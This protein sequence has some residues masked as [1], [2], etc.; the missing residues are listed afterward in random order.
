MPKVAPEH[1]PVFL[2]AVQDVSHDD[3]V[4]QPEQAR[5]NAEAV[6]KYQ[7]Q[8]R[9]MS[10][11][12][13]LAGGN[14]L[15]LLV[16]AVVGL[17]AGFGLS[18]TPLPAFMQTPMG[19]VGLALAGAVG[20]AFLASKYSSP[21]GF[22]S[23]AL[24][25]IVNERAS[26]ILPHKVTGEIRFWVGRALVNWR[27]HEWRYWRGHSYLWLNLPIEERIHDKDRSV[28]EYIVAEDDD[29]RASDAALYV[30]RTLNRRV[31]D[32][33]LNFADYDEGEEAGEHPFMKFVPYGLAGLIVIAGFL[34]AMTSS[35]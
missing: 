26:V 11:A 16:G 4:I 3:A 18:F 34:L 32:T 33:G 15:Q 8:W 30:R 21:L 7:R 29:Y 35:A 12:G 6:K 20:G 25:V 19:V 5:S 23:C 28:L 22:K 2:E 10:S 9:Q 14:Y 13:V 27:A 1:R 31:S 17:F 24:L